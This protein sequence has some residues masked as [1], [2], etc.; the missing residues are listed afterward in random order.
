MFWTG[1]DHSSWFYSFLQAAGAS[2]LCCFTSHFTSLQDVLLRS[3]SR[4]LQT[5]MAP[6]QTTAA[7]NSSSAQT[8]PAAAGKPSS[9]L[10]LQRTMRTAS[11]RRID[12]LTSVKFRS[13]VRRRSLSST[14]MHR[15][16]SSVFEVSAQE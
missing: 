6:P 1:L 7:A 2:W 8:K 16:H 12:G 5:S 11:N 4:A 14:S 10:S 3:L 15:L 9:S 13:Q